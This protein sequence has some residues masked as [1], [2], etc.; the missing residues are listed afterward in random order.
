M[1]RRPGPEK[2]EDVE[3]KVYQ[4]R[5]RFLKNL[6]ESNLSP[7]EKIREFI[8]VRLQV[9]N[10]QA[11]FQEKVD[12]LQSRYT[13]A[14]IAF[15]VFGFSKLIRDFSIPVTVKVPLGLLYFEAFRQLRKYE[16]D[17]PIERLM[18]SASSRL[19]YDCREFLR[20][21]D[22]AH[23]I[24]TS[25][26]FGED[27]QEE[28]SQSRQEEEE[29][30]IMI[31]E[32]ARRRGVFQNGVRRH[33]ESRRLKSQN[34]MKSDIEIGDTVE[35]IEAIETLEPIETYEPIEAFQPVETLEKVEPFQ[36]LNAD[37]SDDETP[38]RTYQ[39][40]GRR[41]KRYHH[42]KDDEDLSALSPHDRRRRQIQKYLER[43]SQVEAGAAKPKQQAAHDY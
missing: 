24:L 5:S 32:K 27:L 10:Y 2:Q 25:K 29:K 8:V 19:A 11:T 33:N 41:I 26:K 37:E 18:S 40:E 21:I 6:K 31:Q 14:T 28:F 42:E 30:R 36:V 1:S 39:T 23:S 38:N 12:I 4:M 17:F 34:E 13:P 15:T 35:A 16:R 7:L 3:A 20:E 9:D 43:K 22:P